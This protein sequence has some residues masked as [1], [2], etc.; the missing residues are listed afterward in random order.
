VRED[1]LDG[2]LVVEV[3]NDLELPPHLRHVSGSASKTFA[4][5][6]AQLAVQRR[7]LAGGRAACGGAAGGGFEEIFGRARPARGADVEG[8]VDLTLEEVLRGTT[9][10]VN[11]EGEG[12]ATARKIEVCIPPGWPTVRVSVPRARAPG[13]AARA[14][15]STSAS[16]SCPTR[17]SSERAPT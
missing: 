16:A 4:M 14:A 11:L 8:T 13:R 10:T 1:L 2:Y 7:F 12:G 9:R 17:G 15:T 3:G 6:R 5:R